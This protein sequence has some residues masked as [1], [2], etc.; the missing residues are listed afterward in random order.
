[1]QR[2]LTNVTLVIATVICVGCASTPRVITPEATASFKRIGVV[3]VTA[4]IL[5]R[6]HVGFTVFGNEEEK[7]DISSWGI[8]NKYEQQVSNELKTLG[9]LEVIAGTYSRP[10]FLHVN[11]LNGPWDAPAFRGPNW[12]AIERPIRGYCKDNQVDAILTIFA[13][14]GPDFIG[15]TNQN[16]CAGLASIRG[17]LAIPFAFPCFI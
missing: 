16:M 15:G 9:G 1:M 6:Q 13:V 8:D 7:I 14:D 10:E 12:K 5:K 2:L 11:D 4:Q 17:A 3:S